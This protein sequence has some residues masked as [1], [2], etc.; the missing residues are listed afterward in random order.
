MNL[1][2]GLSYVLQLHQK[3]WDGGKRWVKLPQ[4]A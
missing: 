4:D 2:G 1:R 3:V